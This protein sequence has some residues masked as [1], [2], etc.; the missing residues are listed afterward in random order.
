MCVR[1]G[2]QSAQAHVDMMCNLCN[3]SHTHRANHIGLVWRERDQKK[4]IGVTTEKGRLNYTE[5]QC[6]HIDVCFLKSIVMG[7]KEGMCV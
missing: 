2:K 5:N 7:E 6:Q 4:K 3:T 1:Y